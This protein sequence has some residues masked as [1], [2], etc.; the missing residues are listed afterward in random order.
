MQY[1]NLKELLKAKDIV[2]D[3]LCEQLELR[4]PLTKEEWKRIVWDMYHDREE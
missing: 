2:I 1:K 4:S 3:M